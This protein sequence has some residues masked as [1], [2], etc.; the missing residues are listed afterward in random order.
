MPIGDA[1]R[2]TAQ[3]QSMN[4]SRTALALAGALLIGTA[5]QAQPAGS[6]AAPGSS[7]TAPDTSAPDTSA[8]GSDANQAVATTKASSPQPAHGANSFTKG[9]AMSRLRKHGYSDVSGLA[10][11][12]GGVW[13][14]TATKDGAQVQVWLDYKGDVGQQ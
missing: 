11:D 13:R 7:T 2:N 3:E 14:G 8:P 6:T 10:K 5:A 1:R 12:R 9:Q 4:Y